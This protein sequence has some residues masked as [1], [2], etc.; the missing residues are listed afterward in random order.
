MGRFSRPIML[1]LTGI[2]G[3]L[4]H[5][6]IYDS[7]VAMY[8][9]DVPRQEALAQCYYDD[10]QFKRFDAD[11]RDACYRKYLTPD[12]LKEPE[13]GPLGEEPRDSNPSSG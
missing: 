8:P 7:W 4:W 2:V 9:E 12:E 13:R 3:I 10:H 11:A 1:I 5:R 6:Q